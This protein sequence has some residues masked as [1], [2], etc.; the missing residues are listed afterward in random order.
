MK[1]IS[2]FITNDNTVDEAISSGR[3][4]REGQIKKRPGYESNK[5]YKI[6]EEKLIPLDSED[7]VAAIWN[8]MDDDTLEYFTNYLIDRLKL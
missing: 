4:K 3:N 8:W 5:Y 1:R 2:D 7:V 6:L